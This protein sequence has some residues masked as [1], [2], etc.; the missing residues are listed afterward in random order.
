[1]KIQEQNKVTQTYDYLFNEYICPECGKKF[2]LPFGTDIPNYVYKKTIKN[3]TK[4]FCSY[5]CFRKISKLEEA[6]A[7][8]KAIKRAASRKK[9]AEVF[10]KT[11]KARAARIRSEAK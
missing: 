9:M 11:A 7:A 5:H 8:E 2:L 10:S 3:R 6:D 1:M 4:M